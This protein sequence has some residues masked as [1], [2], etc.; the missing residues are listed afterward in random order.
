MALVILTDNRTTRLV[1]AYDGLKKMFSL[2]FN[3][4]I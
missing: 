4:P 2:K 3:I 1:P